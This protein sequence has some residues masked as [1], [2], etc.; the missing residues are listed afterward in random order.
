MTEQ[1]RANNN[2]QKATTC[3]S[4]RSLSLTFKRYRC[5]VC[6]SLKSPLLVVLILILLMT[7][8][9]YSKVFKE[10]CHSH[11]GYIYQFEIMLGLDVFPSNFLRLHFNIPKHMVL[12]IS[13]TGSFSRMTSLMGNHR[14]FRIEFQFL[15]LLF[16]SSLLIINSATVKYP[17]INLSKEFITSSV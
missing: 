1:Q 13:P 17:F 11:Y 4:E 10:K 6:N 15:N 12:T 7:I 8:C 5:Y 14:H 2:S 16:S 3:G 9:R